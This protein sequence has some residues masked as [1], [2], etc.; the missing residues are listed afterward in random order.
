MPLDRQQQVI[1]DDA[2][3]LHPPAACSAELAGLPVLAAEANDEGRR[4][5]GGA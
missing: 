5:R 2:H 1:D 4:R 3:R